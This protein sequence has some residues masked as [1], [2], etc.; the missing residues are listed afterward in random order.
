MKESLIHR[1]KLSTTHL[2]PAGNKWCILSTHTKHFCFYFLSSFFCQRGDLLAD[3]S[4]KERKEGRVG[5]HN[6]PPPRHL[7]LPLSLL[8]V[9]EEMREVGQELTPHVSA[10]TV[11]ENSLLLWLKEQNKNGTG[12]NVMT[13]PSVE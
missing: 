3:V 10:N 5:Q 1:Q 9:T 13:Q 6:L 8:W 2:I 4:L 7:H 11:G 12:L